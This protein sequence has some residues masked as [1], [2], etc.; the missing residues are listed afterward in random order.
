MTP[1]WHA[2]GDGMADITDDYM[3]EMFAKT[4]G[5]TLVGLTARPGPGAAHA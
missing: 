2:P 3:R 4:E 1:S 5:Y